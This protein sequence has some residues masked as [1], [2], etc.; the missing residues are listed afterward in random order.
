MEQVELVT[1]FQRRFGKRPEVIGQAPGR[2]NLMGKHVD[3]QGG[4]VNMLAMNRYL[5]VAASRGEGHMFRFRNLEKDRYP[6]Y[7]FELSQDCPCLDG[8][9]EE[10][11]DRPETMSFR[12]QMP[13]WS[14]YM[15]GAV[16]RLCRQ[17]NAL[18]PGLDLL[19]YGDLPPEAGLSSSAALMLSL[20]MGA[21]AIFGW[22]LSGD[23][24]TRLT[25]QAEHFTGAKCGT[26]DA[27]AMVAARP[28]CIVQFG[29]LPFQ[30]KGVHHFPSSLRIVLANSH[31]R[32]PKGGSA[33]ND[34]NWRV[35]AYRIARLL[36]YRLRP[37]WKARMPHLRDLRPETL[38]VPLAEIYRAIREIPERITR[39]G[40]AASG[41]EDR[42]EL[43]EGYA[44]HTMPE[45]GYPLRDILLYGLAEMARSREI[46]EF[47]AREDRER[48]ARW[49][50]RSHD[51]DRVS[52]IRDDVRCMW[53]PAPATDQE[54]GRLIRL[55][56]EGSPEAELTEQTG[57]Y[58][59]STPNVDE[60]VDLCLS[61]EGCLGAQIL[62]GGLGGCM[63]ALVDASAEPAVIERLKT[64]YFEPCDLPLDI[65]SIVP[66]EGAK[67]ETIDP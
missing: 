11:V 32:A 33:R 25:S 21:D 16:L 3:H 6:D 37:D 49:V 59:C 1:E 47:L 54:L 10:A 17:H 5:W 52:M 65:W 30:I 28:D 35:G 40:L 46:G 12:E 42:G 41:P 39:E 29:C 19:A 22:G 13:L 55:A 20:I 66:G 60:M 8:D 57:A 23:D 34:Y 45:G 44:D 38:G 53:R 51:G 27:A 48:L 43:E 7:D 31:E 2:I 50:N 9:W 24:F 18:V 58:L 4:D 64:G 15:A 63:M 56:E 14:R 67:V 62:G 61:V 36:L 26:S